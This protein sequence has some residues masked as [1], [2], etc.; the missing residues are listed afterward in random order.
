MASSLNLIKRAMSIT[1][2]PL[3]QA[4]LAADLGPNSFFRWREDMPIENWLDTILYIFHKEHGVRL[5]SYIVDD[6]VWGEGVMESTGGAGEV[7]S[8]P[9]EAENVSPEAENVPENGHHD[10]LKILQEV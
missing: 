1:W 4:A 2:T 8:V 3:M 10:F 6:D 5:A 7:L 9:P